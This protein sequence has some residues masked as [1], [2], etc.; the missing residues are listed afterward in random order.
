[1][2]YQYSIC[3]FNEM[4]WLNSS[5][6][7]AGEFRHGPYEML[8]ENMAYVFLLDQGESRKTTQRAVDFTRRFT[9]KVITFD[10]GRYPEVSPLLSPFV[11]GATWYWFA[12]TL[13]VLREHPLSVRRYMWKVDY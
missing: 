6:I 12:H 13:S 3:I 1:M 2:N 8:E 10:A 11:I 5:D 4:L 9:D 7:H